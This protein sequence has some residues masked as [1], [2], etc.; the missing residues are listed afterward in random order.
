MVI[1]E[2]ESKVKK[3]TLLRLFDRPRSTYES[4]SSLTECLKIIPL[5]PLLLYS[6][7]YVTDQ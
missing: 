2:K 6:D 4:V 3:Q 5:M 1:F 7:P